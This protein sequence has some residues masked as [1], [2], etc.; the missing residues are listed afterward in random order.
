MRIVLVGKGLMGKVFYHRYKSE[1]VAWVDSDSELKELNIQS[2]VL[3]DFS[4]PSMINAIINYIKEENI[5]AVIATTGYS[6]L[7]EK[8]IVEASKYIAICKDS[9]FSFGML[10][11]KEI[12]KMISENFNGQINLTE[13][14]HINKKDAPSGTALSIRKIIQD[15]DQDV[16]II[17]VRKGNEVG[18]HV[19]KYTFENEIIEIKHQVISKDVFAEGAYNAAKHILNKNRGLFS[20]K[21]VL[22]E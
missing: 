20:Y 21:E 7:E 2:D 22:D 8:E 11:V 10:K 9:N 4:R 16:K 5:P 13:T 18:K 17:S 12:V 19:I 6:S 3:V 1:I 14:H 15:Q